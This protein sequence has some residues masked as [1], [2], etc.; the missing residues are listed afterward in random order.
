MSERIRCAWA[1]DGLMRRYHDE[2][3]GVPVHDDR[4]M[5][6]FLVLEGAQAGLS[7]NTILNRREGYR[8]AF[9]GFEVVKVAE[10]GENE[11]GE[12]MQNPGIIRNRMKINAA[13]QN[14]RAVLK[15]QE[16]T[17]SFA[18]W[19]WQFCGNRPLRLEHPMSLT[20]SPESRLMSRELRSQG[21]GFVGPTICYALMQAV[22]MINDHAL[23]CFRAAE[24]ARLA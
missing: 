12:L 11:I 10:F 21:F 16:E 20:E 18:G 15:I 13:I 19:L 23:D 5:F 1:G 14:A 24:V 2:E 9:A 6:E 4:L 8:E 7:W 3:W 17:G 22:G